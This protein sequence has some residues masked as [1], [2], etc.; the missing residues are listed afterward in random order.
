[1][2]SG[3]LGSRGES[4][5]SDRSCSRYCGSPSATQP[6]LFTVTVTVTVSPTLKLVLVD[7]TKV[8]AVCVLHPILRTS[9]SWTS[10]VDRPGRSVSGSAPPLEAIGR[11]HARNRSAKQT[12]TSHRFMLP[13][14]SP[15]SGHAARPLLASISGCRRDV[16]SQPPL[17]RQPTYVTTR[18]RLEASSGLLRKCPR[19]SWDASNRLPISPDSP[20]SL[21]KGGS[22]TPPSVP[23]RERVV[24]RVLR[25]FG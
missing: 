25:S 16:H 9:G 6:S 7:D 23:V 22:C 14:P 21:N 4:V 1:M 8:E 18:A 24:L 10:R 15:S 13:L 5:S 11:R 20:R 19:I 2:G 3:S 12:G 17:L